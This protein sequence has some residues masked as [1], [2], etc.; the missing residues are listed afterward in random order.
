M[1]DVQQP[2][3]IGLEPSFGFGDRLGLATPG[4]L[5][6]LRS[7][8]GS[9]KPVFAQQ[10]MRE[11]E[12]TRRKPTDVI[13]GA[14]LALESGR[15]FEPW[16]ADANHLKTQEDVNMTASAGFV[17]FT[18]D[19]GDHVDDLADSYD[20]A[21]LEAKFKEVR[22][23]V[24]W[25][26]HY[27]GRRI[28]ISPDVSITFD[29]ENVHRIAVK[30][31]RAIA[32]TIKL[33][34]HIDRV[35]TKRNSDFELEI[36]VSDSRTPTTL[37]EHYIIAEQC[38][39]TGMKMV[40]FA[41]KFVDDF[42]RG[43]DYQGDLDRLTRC[44]QDHAKIARQIGPYKLSLHSGSD[45]MSIYAPFIRATEGKFHIKTAGTSY[46]E[47]LRVAARHERKLFRRIIDFS[48]ERFQ[49]DR[50]TYHIT[51]ELARVPTP[52]AV[53]D[54]SLLERIYLDEND[55]R[56][57]LHVT[58]GSVLTD[59]TLG[60]VLRDVLVANPETHREILKQHFGKH[61]QAI[62]RSL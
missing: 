21:T 55:G 29:R 13:Q 22:R 28:D 17:M 3:T 10:S 23:D 25:S 47:S 54:D 1:H 5:D 38:L 48:R 40:S 50:V 37:A 15:Y 46:L 57:V 49:E 26:D 42:V 19:P 52:A 45:K 61:L 33:A 41:P 2:T 11:L 56:Q 44:F 14:S 34:A 30:Y 16:C 8:G 60:P 27:I 58:Y 12:R 39:R 59:T 20:L 51:A 6:A 31:G 32:H 62:N 36:C 7:Y 53:G 18:I 43:I 4:H 35:M 9:L 24:N